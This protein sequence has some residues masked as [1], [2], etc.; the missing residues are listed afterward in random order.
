MSGKGT[1]IGNDP[2]SFA[3]RVIKAQAHAVRQQSQTRAADHELKN[4]SHDFVTSKTILRFCIISVILVSD[5]E[6][7][8]LTVPNIKRKVRVRKSTIRLTHKFQLKSFQKMKYTVVGCLVRSLQHNQIFESE[9][10]VQDLDSWLSVSR[11]PATMQSC[12]SGLWGQSRKNSLL[13]LVSK[14]PGKVPVDYLNRFRCSKWKIE[15]SELKAPVSFYSNKCG[16]DNKWERIKQDERICESQNSTQ[17][18][19]DYSSDANKDTFYRECVHNRNLVS[20]LFIASSKNQSIYHLRRTTIVQQ[21]RSELSQQLHR[22]NQDCDA[23]DLVE[24]SWQN[25]PMLVAFSAVCLTSP[26]RPQDHQMSSRSLRMSDARKFIPGFEYGGA[27]E[28]FKRQI[29]KNPRT[30]KAWEME[31]TFAT[32]NS[33]ALYQ[34]I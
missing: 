27:R 7:V 13:I 28:S 32:G 23:S 5:T 17:C 6:R 21:Y 9:N 15:F 33:R 3:N 20:P 1:I 29:V 30:S 8:S 12:T 2:A 26:I 10:N 19:T 25:I 31:K 22:V 34:L 16:R 18:R 24:E 4:H 14:S 11:F